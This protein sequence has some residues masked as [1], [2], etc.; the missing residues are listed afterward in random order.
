V[1]DQS[2]NELKKKL[3]L[4]SRGSQLISKIKLERLENT[5]NSR[6]GGVD[7]AK[8]NIASVIAQKESVLPSQLATQV[9]GVGSLA[10][11]VCLSRPFEVIPMVVTRVQPV[12]AA[13]QLRPSDN[14]LDAQERARPG[15]LT[16]VME[17][18]YEGDMEGDMPGSKC[19][20]NAYTN[21][22]DLL[23][24]GD[25]GVLDTLFY[26]PVDA[27]GVVHAI[28]LRIQALVMPVQ[29]LVFA[30]H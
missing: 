8:A 22:H 19:I 29:M 11:V 10:E 21:K 18:L 5:V 20:S 14:L 9:I 12:V 16:V 1:L 26:H 17:P 3:E 30:G 27:V 2:E 13:G 25:I 15:T 7:T 28:V 6:N 4:S 23:A 24:S